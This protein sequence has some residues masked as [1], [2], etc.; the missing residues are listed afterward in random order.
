MEPTYLSQLLGQ[1]SPTIRPRSDYLTGEEMERAKELYANSMHLREESPQPIKDLEERVNGLINVLDDGKIKDLL[2]FLETLFVSTKSLRDRIDKL[3]SE[4]FAFAFDNMEDVLARPKEHITAELCARVFKD[5]E[6]NPNRALALEENIFRKNRRLLD[7]LFDTL[8]L[9][10]SDHD[11]LIRFSLTL[12]AYEGGYRA[13]ESNV[14]DVMEYHRLN[15]QGFK[16][17]LQFGK[18]TDLVNFDFKGEVEKLRDQQPEQPVREPK[19]QATKPAKRIRKPKTPKKPK[20]PTREERIAA[21]EELSG[22]AR[23]KIASLR[24]AIEEQDR[25]APL[26]QA[27]LIELEENCSLNAQLIDGD[28]E[29]RIKPLI[30]AFSKAAENLRSNKVSLLRMQQL[31]AEGL[32]QIP[33]RPEE[34]AS[35]WSPAEKIDFLQDDIV[36][37]LLAAIETT[38]GLD[39]NSLA[40]DLEGYKTTILMLSDDLAEKMEKNNENVQRAAALRP[41][42]AELEAFSDE[43]DERAR[44]LQ[45]AIDIAG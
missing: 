18:A 19:P 40:A 28:I 21:L 36:E 32:K 14:A 15:P 43:L 29:E 16:T 24:S 17:F 30:T 35:N 6:E 26:L 4:A 27:E 39:A 44:Q 12:H 7:Q 38:N 37:E 10:D 13:V 34:P 23:D 22:R 9:A 31:D 2:P 8:S 20:G 1:P 5:G 45:M 3:F 11:E 33:E 25:L 41:W 42:L